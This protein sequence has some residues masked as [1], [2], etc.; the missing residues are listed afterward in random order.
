[1]AKIQVGN[2][3]ELSAVPYI[4]VVANVARQ[5][6]NLRDAGVGGL[7][8]SWTLGGYPSPNME[9]VTEVG[10]G[11]TAEAALL[12]VARRRFGRDAAPAVVHAWQAFSTAF[13]EYPYHVGGLYSG[14]QQVGPA[15]PLWERPTGYRATM[16]GFPYDDVDAWR[17]AYPAEVYADQFER[18]AGGFE[19]AVRQLRRATRGVPGSGAQLT[20][21]REEAAIGEVCAIHFRSVANQTRFVAARGA[22]AAAD[23]P[24]AAAPLIAEL[25]RL[26]QEEIGL[27]ERLQALQAEDSRF[28]YEASN[29]YYYV[30]VDLA[31]KVLNCR[32]LLD[33]WLPAERDRRGL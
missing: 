32:D 30:D 15:N 14:P 16:V 19:A 22:L 23:A 24:E 27:A 5:A 3:W 21:L 8:L 1:M 25:S 12:A 9:V 29:Q 33:R 7:M 10:R 17:A 26:L 11:A 6:A 20:A 2:T 13:G 4:P 18:V 31:E 28:G